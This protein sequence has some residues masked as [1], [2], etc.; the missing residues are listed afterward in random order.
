[1]EGMTGAGLAPANGNSKHL[2]EA[3]ADAITNAIAQGLLQPGERLIETAVAGQLAV[4]RVPLREALRTLE[5]QGIVVVTPNRGARIVAM[6]EKT[7]AD[8]QETRIAL[9]RIAARGAMA[10][11]RRDPGRLKPLRDAVAMMVAAER[12]L[13]WAA[14]RRSDIQFH[15]ELCVASGNEVALKLWEALSRHIAIIFGREIEAEHDFAVVIAQHEHLIDL[16]ASASPTVFEEI[17]SHVMRLSR[18][19]VLT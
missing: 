1:M 16:L 3:I 14:L 13:D 12:Q 7:V 2:S 6:D 9:E 8:V 17:E 5:A 19:A 11:F 15:H 10:V 4:S 18:R